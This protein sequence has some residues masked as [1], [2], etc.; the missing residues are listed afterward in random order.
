MASAACAE[1]DPEL[2]FPAAGERGTAA[3]RICAG[4]PVRAQCLEYA[5][6][7]SPL[8]GVWAGLSVKQLREVAASRGL[9]RP[10]YRCGEMFTS[11]Q[12]GAYCGPECRAAA[13]RAQSTASRRGRA[14]IGR[15]A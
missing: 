12:R 7:A 14:R 8:Y 9:P 13:R 15:A 4:C 3:R 10:C 6:A 1:V 5:L 11:P 2:W